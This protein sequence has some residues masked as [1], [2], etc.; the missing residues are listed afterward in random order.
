MNTEIPIY[1]NIKAFWVK[2][3]IVCYKAQFFLN[4]DRGTPGSVKLDLHIRR[5]FNWTNWV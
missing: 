1:K 3:I 2:Y 4:K 5:A